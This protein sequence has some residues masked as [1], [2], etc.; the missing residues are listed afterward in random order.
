MKVF[1][2]YR[3]VTS[4]NMREN[5]KF[6]IQI[7]IFFFLAYVVIVS[8]LILT[9]EARTQSKPVVAASVSDPTEVIRSDMETETGEKGGEDIKDGDLANSETNKL[10][11]M[12]PQ[13]IDSFPNRDSISN[14]STPNLCP[15][16]SGVAAST[17]GDDNEMVQEKVA[18]VQ[19]DITSVMET[20]FCGIDSSL[21]LTLKL[22]V[23]SNSTTTMG[24]PKS[25]P[26]INKS[27]LFN[28]PLISV[29]EVKS[30]TWVAEISDIDAALPTQDSPT[31]IAL[32]NF[33]SQQ[34]Q[35]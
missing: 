32:I 28:V 16:K 9:D 29:E 18:T 21:M 17:E 27:S 20:E 2:V 5:P 22:A 4:P 14:V 7:A 19:A 3:A 33:N 25:Q 12:L 10:E 34:S 26:I 1:L 13:D 11:N 23:V 24:N 35:R 8:S 31:I 6:F 15:I 30:N